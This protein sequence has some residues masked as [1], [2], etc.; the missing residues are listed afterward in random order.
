VESAMLSPEEYDKKRLFSSGL[1]A[2]IAWVVVAGI[3]FLI[4]ISAP[5]A[6]ETSYA[7]V[8]ITLEPRTPAPSVSSVS[9][10][11]SS[12]AETQPVSAFPETV[13][14][15][16]PPPRAELDAAS[17]AALP[18]A[19]T[20]AAKARSSAEKKKEPAQ[21]QNPPS[22]AGLGIPNF[23]TPLSPSLSS[24]SEG[25]YLEFTSQSTER[26]APS[27]TT[28][29]E[30]APPELVGAA[31]SVRAP[32]ADERRLSTPANR[33]SSSASPS[34]ATSS[35]LSEIAGAA[36]RG[37]STTAQTSPSAGAASSPSTG[38]AVRP[39]SQAASSSSLV[40]GLDF[41][42]ESRRPIAP[43]VPRITLPDSLARLVDSNRSVTV[44]FTVRADGLVPSGT[45]I[46]SPESVL[47]VEIRD[48]LRREF[49]QWRF[50]KSAADGQAKFLYSIK[51]E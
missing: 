49:S 39:A 28:G 21:L 13:P 12:V 22:P 38:A 1:I 45:V 43:A 36:A 35:A 26:P 14:I 51:V 8:L 44:T 40:S 30:N 24:A 3:A 4:P 46:F 42:G 6:E 27:A 48:Y 19:A 31:A 10:V 32:S 47:P 16:N 41:E 2:L 29:S 23:S 50:E 11:R 33:P 20:S 17:S 7:S 18:S 5:R 9:S 37:S 15:Q 25:A 34:E